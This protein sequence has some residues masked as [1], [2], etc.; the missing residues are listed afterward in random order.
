M[1]VSF[2]GGGTDL[3]PL[4]PGIGGRV[5]GTA[6]DL[7]VQAEVEPF[8]RGWVR[9]ELSAMDRVLTRRSD[10]PPESDIAFRLLEAT[11]AEVGIAD[12]VRIRIETSVVPGAGL[13]GSGAA[14]VA[15]MAALMASTLE[16][17]PGAALSPDELA[18]SALRVERER[19]RL[20]CGPQDPMFAALGGLLDL[21][22]GDAGAVTHA[23]LPVAP[24]FLE[25]F[26]GGLMLL[27][28]GQRRVSGEV[29]GR[30]QARAE[31]NAELVAAAGDVAAGFAAGSL[32]QVLTGMRRSAA[33]KLRRDPTVSLAATAMAEHLGQHGAEVVRMCGAG[34]GGHVLLWAPP[35]RHAAIAAAI[36]CMVRKPALAAPGVRIEAG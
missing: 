28:T 12:A 17:S 14:A 24:G 33:A 35:E 15:V 5:V 32:S 30:M 21:R 20:T 18:T 6:I 31:I 13:G 36:G 11:L 34:E 27:D 23:P 26:A 25:V 29:I 7:R 3:P 16:G 4:L 22:F 8:D 10:D 2:A 1:R 9:L 19:L